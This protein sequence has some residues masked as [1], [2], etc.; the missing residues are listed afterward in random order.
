MFVNINV[1]KN[2]Y[3]QGLSLINLNSKKNMSDPTR[4]KSKNPLKTIKLALK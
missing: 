4:E 2:L 1:E 3:N